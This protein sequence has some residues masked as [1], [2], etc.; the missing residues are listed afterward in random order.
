MDFLPGFCQGI[1]RVLISH[2]FDYVRLYLQT[3][4]SSNF[5]DFFKKNSVRTLYRGVGVPLVSVP[6]DRSIQFRVYEELNNYNLSPFLSGSIC[7]G[8]SVF[9]TLPTSFI[10][11]NYVLNKNE[12]DLIK[13]TRKIFQNPTQLYNGFK[14]ELVRSI[15]GTSI[16]LGSYGKMRENYGN[17]LYQSVINGAVAGWSVWTITYP[18]ETVKVEQQISNRAIAEILKQRISNFGVL[19]LWKGILPVYLRTLPSSI[20]GMT[21]YEEVKKITEN[22]KNKF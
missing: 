4:N 14:P 16:Y 11:N 17:D 22:N 20:I 13:F 1:S 18:I 12:G 19:N 6:I 7:G 5:S 2:P 8:I 15:L 10:C 3:N 21:V 9:F